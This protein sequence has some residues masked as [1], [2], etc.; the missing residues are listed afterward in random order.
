M[1]TAGV[2]IGLQL[3]GPSAWRQWSRLIGILTGCALS[4]PLGLISGQALLSADWVGIPIGSYPS[5]DFRLSVEFWGLLPGFVIV[6]LATTTYSISD[7]VVMQQN[8]WR[9]PRAT[10]F[11]MIQGAINTLVLSN[12]VA[13]FAGGMPN[14][15]AP[16]NTTR[17]LLTGV[18]ARR[19][20]LYAGGVLI[21]A[22][23]LPKLI[24]VATTVPK[25]VFVAFAMVGMSLLFV[26]GM[27]QVVQGGI[28]ARK[29]M[30]VGLSFWLG[31]GFQN[32]LIFPDVFVGTLGVLL[33]NGLTVGAVTLIAFTLLLELT[34]ARR[35]RLSVEFNGDAFPKLDG[36][37]R[38]FAQSAGWNE[39]SANRLRSAGEETLSS[40]LPQ[41]DSRQRLVVSS[42][43]MEGKIELE[44]VAFVD[45]GNL[46][47]RLAYL[48]EQPEIEDDRELSFRLLRHYASSVKHRKYRNTDIITVEVQG[49]RG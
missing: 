49:P 4:I 19:M 48:S 9:M 8:A 7:M 3:F 6:V 37:L 41:E 22:A 42:Q 31:V 34:S 43:R 11:R 26:Q 36:F 10:D 25:P 40:L 20:G 38:E 39:A 1:V 27:R 21:A 18:A 17:L 47:D 46:E 15:L 2:I 23:F 30:M 45:D 13:A 32:Q 12:L 28:D 14:Q 24:A 44:F 5:F 16:G 33:S 29:A 35:K